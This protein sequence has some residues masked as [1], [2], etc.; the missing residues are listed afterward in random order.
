MNYKNKAN[1]TL[2][3]VF[4]AFISI[5]ILKYVYGDLIIISFL[6]MVLEASM[7]GGAADWFAITAIFRKPLCIS[8]HTAIIPRNRQKII[9]GITSAVENELLTKEVI[10][11]KIS[12]LNLSS[13]IIYLLEKNKFEILNYLEKFLNEYFN[14]DGKVKLLKLGE[15]IKNNQLKAHSLTDLLNLFSKRIYSSGY[16]EKIVD[17]IINEIIKMCRD[18]K[19]ELFIY[20]V[21]IDI[22]EEKCDNFLSRL[23]F[24]LLEK[25]D[26]VNLQNA[27]VNFKLETIEELSNMKNKDNCYRQILKKEIFQMFLSIEESREKIEV[28]KEELIDSI[29]INNMVNKI[30]EVTEESSLITKF[31]VNN[32]QIYFDEVSKDEEFKLHLD[33]VMKFALIKFAERN[34]SFIGSL[35]SETLNHYDDKKLNGFIDDKFGEDLQ[36]IRING[37]VVGG[38]IGGILFIFL[39]LLYDP[40]VVPLIRRIVLKK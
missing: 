17:N 28:A 10:E 4:I 6:F 30:T 9:D 18:G 24:G 21:L 2:L 29:D 16:E 3:C 7:V 39:K 25:T 31:I 1:I 40:F 15:G 35:V 36:W 11:E 26:S 37:S 23:S 8:F 12:Q 5:T 13:K 20:K 32:I 38:I 34:H 33:N 27:A 14:G 22:K 19:L